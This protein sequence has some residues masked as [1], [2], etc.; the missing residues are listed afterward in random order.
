MLK[1]TIGMRATILP[2]DS[3]L[4]RFRIKTRIKH[5]RESNPPSFSFHQPKS[6]PKSPMPQMMKIIITI[7]FTPLKNGVPGCFCRP[8]IK[9]PMTMKMAKAAS[10]N[11]RIREIQR[12]V[13]E[14]RVLFF[15]ITVL[16]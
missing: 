5:E 8:S 6:K 2:V 9:Y 13:L 12:S 10:S 7:G 16:I 14:E 1:I 3:G 4:K 15:V 11:P